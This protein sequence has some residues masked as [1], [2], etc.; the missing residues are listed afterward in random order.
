MLTLASL[1]ETPA[2][3][4]LFYYSRK[5]SGYLTPRM[6]GMAADAIRK[7]SPNPRMQNFVALSGHSL[8][9]PSQMPLDMFQLAGDSPAMMPGVSDWMSLGS[10]RWDSHQSV[11]FSVAMYNAGARRYG[12][13][14]VSFP[15]MHCVWPSDFRAYTM[16]A[17]QVRYVS[18]YNFGPSYAVT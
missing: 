2:E 11:A 14:P 6:F 10:W 3:A 7:Y 9:F 12:E 5:Y 15:M 1:V 13:E 16:L 4:C 18:F 8:Y 17:N